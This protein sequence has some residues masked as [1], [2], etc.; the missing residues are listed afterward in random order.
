M[1]KVKIT[2]TSLRDGH[3]SLI[4]TRLTTEEMLPILEKMDQAGYHAM[5]VWGGATFDSCLRFLNEDPWERLRTIRKHVKNTKLQML[6]RGQNLLGYRHYADD[7]VEEFIKKAVQNGID[8]IRVFDA[9]NDTRN[10]E[11][12]IEVIKR[13]GAHCQ[14]AI[15]YATSKVHGTEYFLELIKKLESMGA[16]SIC[17]KDM[18]G[19]LKP[20][21]AYNF[22]KE[23]KKITD[24]PIELHNHCTGG[25]AEMTVLKAI[26]AGVDIVDTAISPFSSGTS[27]PCT[28]T[29]V[30][31]L[32][33]T[34][35]ETDLN[36]D[37]LNEVADYLK[38]VRDKYLQNGVLDPK[39]YFV[40]PKT[41]LYQV[42]GG[43]LSNLISQLKALNA[44]NKF[45]EVLKEIPAVREDLGFPPLV[46][47][48]SQMVGS[49]A[50]FNV[51]MGERY[52]MVPK[53]VKKYVQGYY[54]KPPA[55]I[56]D[57]I[58]TKIIGNDEVITKRP[59]DLLENEIEK[60][61]A[62]IEDLYETMED[63]LSYVLFPQPAK[64]FLENR[65]FNSYKTAEGYVG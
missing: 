22:I 16:D 36:I 61:R 37:V 1:K 42:P 28:E 56:S 47:P 24:L 58:K 34:E 11:K 43:M 60:A 52:K 23:I 39:V 59:A 14:C 5:E 32:A 53:E 9:L 41:L 26:E 40:E 38:K 4:A 27:Q 21:D 12:S 62:E 50:V 65:K 31:A 55:P 63:V 54:G 3:Q 45:D 7:V 57:E 25:V 8:I 20:Y 18:S 2:E 15:S 48:L 44:E 51:I 10:M 17:I 30:E 46:T 33:G 29:L 13:E 64:D 49:Q 35:R 19:I 6:L